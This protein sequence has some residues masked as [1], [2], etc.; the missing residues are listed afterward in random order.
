AHDPHQAEAVRRAFDEGLLLITGGPGTGKTTTIARLLAL[1][2]QA[3]RDLRIALAAPTGRAAERMAESLRAARERL[4]A[5]G[6]DP[7]LLDA[8]PAEA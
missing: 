5:D 6:V 7:A 3:K 4:R 2:L 8:L 1:R